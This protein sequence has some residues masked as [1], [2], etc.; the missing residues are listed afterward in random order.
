M[1]L[2]HF[3]GRKKIKYLEENWG[4]INVRLTDDEQ[5]E[6]GKFVENG[7][8]GFRSTLAGI[9]FVFADTKVEAYVD[10]SGTVSA[11]TSVTATFFS[12]RFEE[13]YHCCE[14]IMLPNLYM[15]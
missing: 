14:R 10:G 5:A 4:T 9:A 1:T 8:L 6:I 11:L 12:S 3:P 13:S 2:V 7:R 15:K